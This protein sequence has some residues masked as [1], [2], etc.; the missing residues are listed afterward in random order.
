MQAA[1][2]KRVRDDL[3][4]IRAAAGLELPFG[5]EDIWVWWWMA[6]S[7]L[8][9]SAYMYFAPMTTLHRAIAIVPMLLAVAVLVWLRYRYRRNTGRS[10]IRRQEY[11]S[12]MIQ[13]VVALPLVIGFFALARAIDVPPAARGAMALFAVGATLLV[14][15]L[16][17]AVRRAAIPPGLALLALA[18]AV[19]MLSNHGVVIAAGFT[20]TVAATGAALVMQYQLKRA[21]VDG[22][23]DG[24]H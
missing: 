24:S 19:P 5:R 6:G 15:G 10:A 22:T 17:S 11:S 1:E 4:T 20:M 23:G 9:M 14:I 21:A 13:L 3:A 8:F 7:G 2:L 12:G 18:L 16:C